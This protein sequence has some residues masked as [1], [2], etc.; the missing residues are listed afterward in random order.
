MNV[1]DFDYDL[2]ESFIAQ[3]PA[4]PRDS[5]RLMLM[6]RATG[7][8]EHRIFHEIVELIDPG[9]VLVLNSTR[10]IPARLRATK[11]ETGGGVEILLL[12]QLDDTGWR[13]LVGGRRVGVGTALVF[14]GSSITAEVMEELDESERMIR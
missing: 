11:K 13:A 7:A 12:R 2:P 3:T 1:S 6:D 10:V 8:L 14:S 4:E 5:S 9:D